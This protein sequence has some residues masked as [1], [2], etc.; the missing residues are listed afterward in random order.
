MAIMDLD[1]RLTISY[2]MNKM[3]NVGLGNDRTKAYAKAVY[4][5]MGCSAGRQPN[6]MNGFEHNFPKSDMIGECSV[7]MKQQVDISLSRNL[8]VLIRWT[9]NPRHPTRPRVCLAMSD[10]PCF[11]WQI[12]P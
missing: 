1:R 7:A 5:A 9:F 2:A 6:Q 3:D 10:V 11:S 12:W 8:T 4:K